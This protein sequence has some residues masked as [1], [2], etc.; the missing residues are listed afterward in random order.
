MLRV[1]GLVNPIVRELV[2]M[3]Y[4][5]EEPFIVDSSKI[6][7]KLGVQATPIDKA[8]DDTLSTYRHG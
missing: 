5:F 4:Q 3:Q 7:S 6:A 8:L 2:E 1:L